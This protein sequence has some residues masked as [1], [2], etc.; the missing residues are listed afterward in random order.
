[1]KSINHRSKSKKS[2][3]IPSFVGPSHSFGTE[4]MAGAKK[5]AIASAK[6]IQNFF[7]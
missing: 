7:F 4:A 2:K 6:K 3:R 5:K 1:M